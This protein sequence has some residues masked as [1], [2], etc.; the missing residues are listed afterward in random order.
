MYSRL[1]ASA[2]VLIDGLNS[3]ACWNWTNSLVLVVIFTAAAATLCA[4]WMV[5]N[6]GPCCSRCPVKRVVPFL[7]MMALFFVNRH[8]QPASHNFPMLSRFVP[9]RAGNRSVCVACV[10]RPG[11]CRLAVCVDVM[12]DPSGSRTSM[13]FDVGCLLLHGTLSP[14][15]CPVDPV[16]AIAIAFVGGLRN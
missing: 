3:A 11:M 7:W 1:K 14:L 10:G 12:I 9:P 5:H 16:S 15:K 2:N 8:S 4:N 6:F 13:G